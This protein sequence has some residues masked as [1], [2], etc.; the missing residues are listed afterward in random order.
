MRAYLKNTSYLY[1]ESLLL[2]RQ[3]VQ[4]PGVYSAIIESIASGYTKANEISTKIG[5]D[6]AKCLKYIKTLCE[7]GILYKETPWGDKESSRKT[8]YGISDFMFRF[9][10]RYVFTNRSLVETG[11]SKAIWVKKINPDYNNYMGIVFE[12]VCM[13]YLKEQNARG[14][15]PFL[16]TSIGRWWGTNPVTRNQI[17]IDIVANDNK[18][19]LI[20]EC[21]WRNEKLDVTIL[22]QLKEKADI[23]HKNREN[24][25][26][27]LFSKSGFTETVIEEAKKDKNILLVDVDRLME[28]M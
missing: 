14:E 2:L 6:A 19:F 9:W 23:F 21:K 5:E 17:E 12:K 15:L 18:D 10:Y 7:L 16:F 3:E 13:D 11:A 22:R 8:I 28:A 1:E 27:V 4:E 24:T 26:Y 20:G 25:W